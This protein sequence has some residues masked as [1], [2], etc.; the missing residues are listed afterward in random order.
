MYRK[1]NVSGENLMYCLSCRSTAG[2][3]D[4]ATIEGHGFPME[5]RRAG[6]KVCVY[7]DRL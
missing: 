1:Q 7:S 2:Y 6:F 3:A 4:I 5:R